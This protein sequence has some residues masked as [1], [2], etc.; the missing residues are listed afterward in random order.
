MILDRLLTYYQRL[1]KNFHLLYA[2]LL[3]QVSKDDLH[4]FRVNLKKQLA[5]IR[6]M[7][8]LDDKFSEKVVSKPFK[9]CLKN[10]G[11][12]RDLEVGQE[13]VVKD[14]TNHHLGHLFSHT[15]KLKEQAQREVFSK[16]TRKFSIVP[17]RDATAVTLSHLQHLGN[18]V[19]V[20]VRLFDYFHDQLDSVRQLAEILTSKHRNKTL[21]ELRTNVKE[22]YLNIQL[23][24]TLVPG[25]KKLKPV[26]AELDEMQDLLGNWHDRVITL[27]K[28]KGE[29]N[30]EV[31]ALKQ[32]VK[33]EEVA[34][35][36]TMYR[37]LDN[38]TETYRQVLEVLR[39]IFSHPPRDSRSSQTDPR[40]K[41][42]RLR[43]SIPQINLGEGMQ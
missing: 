38:F 36:N 35:R 37:K 4:A 29:K 15:L 41:A 31:K 23:L 24:Q 3:E 20:W 28:M 8:Y 30:K 9:A 27:N 43:S 10:T 5:F 25:K 26:I 33:A 22:L 12:L 11:A 19:D 7:S 39:D 14:E 32:V 21:H 6:L 17:A 13:I 40:T 16:F 2:T 1:D 34:L 18:R 42:H